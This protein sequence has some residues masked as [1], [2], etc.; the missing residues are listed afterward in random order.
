MCRAT[1]A[2]YT[3]AHPAS[4]T[5]QHD[6]SRGTEFPL[7]VPPS[8]NVGEAFRTLARVIATDD[9]SH[10]PLVA[11]AVWCKAKAL[12]GQPISDQRLERLGVQVDKIDR[13]AI[14]N[15]AR[16]Q[17]IRDRVQAHAQRCGYDGPTPLNIA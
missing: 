1:G 11:V 4:D 6:S 3:L 14:E 17:R 10:H 8:P 9:R 12:R 7:A 2:G 15:A 13:A 16:A 5:S